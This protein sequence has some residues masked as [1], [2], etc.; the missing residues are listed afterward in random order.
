MPGDKIS[1]ELFLHILLFI[2]TRG[3]ITIERPIPN[4]FCAY[5]G[6]FLTQVENP[7]DFPA[8]F[9]CPTVNRAA[10]AVQG[11]S[12]LEQVDGF[13]F[14]G[15]EQDGC[16]HELHRQCLLGSTAEPDGRALVGFP[17]PQLDEAM[18]SGNHSD[19]RAFCSLLDVNENKLAVSCFLLLFGRNER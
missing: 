6:E 19:P 17:P 5:V 14:S 10:R 13:P 12:G 16:C 7:P 9:F 4:L 18:E 3:F 2:A 15:L 11:T 8:W 1:A